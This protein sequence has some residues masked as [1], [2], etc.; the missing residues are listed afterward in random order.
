M[1][2]VIRLGDS[3]SH[4]GKVT[5]ACNWFTVGGIAVA[6]QGDNCTCPKKGHNNC[7]IAEGDPNYV[8]EGRPVAL[9]GHKTT[10]G[11]VLI[12]SG[13]NNGREDAPG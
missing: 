3:T 13:A 9:E 1:R 8:I 12:A 5:S 6:R 11:A 2:R 4:G 10:C 7:K